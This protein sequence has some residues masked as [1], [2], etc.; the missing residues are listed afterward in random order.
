LEEGDFDALGLD[1]LLD[2]LGDVTDVP[3]ELDAG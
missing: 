1:T 3:V 2:L